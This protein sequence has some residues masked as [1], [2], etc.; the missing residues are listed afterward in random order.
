MALVNKYRVAVNGDNI[1]ILRPIP[2]PQRLTK[3]EALELAAW[4]VAL[5]D[6]SERHSEFSGLLDIV[7]NS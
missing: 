2:Q 6:D 5:A 7:V 4:L 1:V 3:A